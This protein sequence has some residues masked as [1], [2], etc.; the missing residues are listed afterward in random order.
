MS[1]TKIE[2]EEVEGE[3]I[4]S[5]DYFFVKVG[6]AVPLKSSDF[7]FEVET[8]PS[9]AIA[10]SERFRLTFVAHSCGF[11]VVRTK[12]LIDSANEFKEKRNGSPVQ[13]LSL[14]DVS[15]GRIRSLTLS[16]DN[17]TL[18]AVT[19]LSGDIR[20]Y[21]VESFLNKEV[22]QSFSCSLDDSAL[23]KDMRWIT[24]QKNSYIVLSNTGKLYHGEIGFPLKQVMDNV[25]AEF[26]T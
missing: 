7:N 10:I 24:T 5:T 22:K 19:S 14:V 8:L 2:P 4:G 20:F 18:A 9:Q 11:F 15:I 25:D 3:I 26:G 16:T 12:D 17:L 6:E 1:P 21:S 23:V 13:Q